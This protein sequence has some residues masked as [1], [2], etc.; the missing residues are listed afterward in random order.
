VS[1]IEALQNPALFKHTVKK[2]DFIETHISWVF[3]TGEYVY[4]IK[5]PLNLGFLDFSS[6]EKRHFY[7][8]EEIRLNR[9]L[10]PQLYLEVVAIC[11]SAAQPNL[12]ERGPV[13]EYAVK[14]RQF[15]QSAQLDRLSSNEKLDHRIIDKLASNVANFHLAIKSA[16]TDSIFGDLEHIRQPM[17]ENFQ[18]IRTC[19]D[20]IRIESVLHKL[21]RW[22][23]QQ[24][25]ELTEFIRQRKTKGFIRECH[26]DM[27]LRNIAWW[28]NEIIIFDC[29][30]FNKN[31]FWIDVISDIAFLIMDLEDRQQNA[32]A[33]RF[34]NRYLEITGDYAGVRLLIFYKVYRA[35]VRAKVDAIRANQEAEGTQVYHEAFNNF[36]QYLHLA[37]GYTN[38]AS[39]CLLINHGLSGSGKSYL[40]QLILEKFPAI[41]I[42]SDVERKRLFQVPP[43]KVNSGAVEQGIYTAEATSRTYM[44]LVKIAKKM[45]AAGYS[46]IIDAANLKQQQR[47][48][49]IDLATSM[50]VPFL[51]IDYRAPLNILRRRIEKRAKHQDDVSDATHEVLAHQLTITEPFASLER[52]F[53]LTINTDEEIKIDNVI[54][55]IQ[56]HVDQYAK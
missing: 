28:D 5:K 22:S 53:V 41:Q 51:I 47:Q 9:R 23:Q 48:L 27:H 6:L 14:M 49:F 38:A 1:L 55:R 8:Q 46:V 35:L 7:C 31:F 39:P 13:I 24:F 4:K 40:S 25:D 2:I 45:L 37:E 29:I 43:D 50:H 10:A 44:Q 18:H 19:V 26:G 3:L 33:N 32:L 42:R 16:S 15:P 12:E 56:S 17:L 11:G 21:E 36:V 34:L 30:E 20:N 54:N 52:P